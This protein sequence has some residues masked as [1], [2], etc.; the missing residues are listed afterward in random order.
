MRHILKTD[1]EPFQQI[2]NGHK[3]AEFRQEDDRIFKPLERLDL[4]E[5]TE[6][7]KYTGRSIIA[8]ITH[9]QR[10]Y[11]IPQGYAMVSFSVVARCPQVTGD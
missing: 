10:G 3:K 8:S 4:L 2:W 9:V 11:G 1:Q 7:G 6:P 5:Q